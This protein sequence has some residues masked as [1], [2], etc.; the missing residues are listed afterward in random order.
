MLLQLIKEL[1]CR[2]IDQRLELYQRTQGIGI[3]DSPAEF[4]VK[5]LILRCE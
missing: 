5:S 3:C 1:G 2:G 4:G